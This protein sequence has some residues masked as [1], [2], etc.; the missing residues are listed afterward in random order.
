MISHLKQ[1]QQK[2]STE[3]VRFTKPNLKLT[4]PVELELINIYVFVYF[5]GYICVFAG[6][7]L[8]GI[9]KLLKGLALRGL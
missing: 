1:T 9:K 3:F 5:R 7:A 4:R 6:E 8:Q 2:A